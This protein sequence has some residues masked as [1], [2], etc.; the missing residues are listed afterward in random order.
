MNKADDLLSEVTEF[1]KSMRGDKHHRFRSWEHCYQFF[2]ANPTNYDLASLHLGF[3][4]AS[5]GMYRGSSFLLQKDYRIHEG[6]VKEILNP[7]YRGL[8]DISLDRLNKNDENEVE[9]IFE[10]IDWLK[11]FYRKT[12]E[13]PRREVNVTDT[14]ATKI[15]MGTLGCIPA[16]DRFFIAGIKH[17]GLSY[18]YLN[19]KNFSEMI[20][21]CLE[22]KQ[23]FE[24]AQARVSSHGVN[25]PVMKIVDMYFW[26]LGEQRDS[27]KTALS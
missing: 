19:K 13:L 26:R 18:S 22:Q 11:N 21:F 14:L 10:L 23:D 1:H 16:Y 5:W 24:K 27:G 7:R 6:A 9:L 12:T 2:G 8:R 4:L 17:H 15:L 3:Y 25:Y 20:A